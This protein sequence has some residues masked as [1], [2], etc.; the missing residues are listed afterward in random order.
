MKLSE[1][2]KKSETKVSAKSHKQNDIASKYEELKDCSSDELLSR[3]TKEIQSQK[4]SGTFDFDGLVNTIERIKVYLP[5]QT[6]QNM[7]K[8]IESFKWL[9]F[10]WMFKKLTKDF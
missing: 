2:P 3:L 8:I 4:D 1:M 7:L 6:Y 10:I 5:N 9:S